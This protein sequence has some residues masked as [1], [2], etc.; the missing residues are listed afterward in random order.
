MRSAHAL[1]RVRDAQ[2]DDAPALQAIV[3]GGGSTPGE[4]HGSAGHLADHFV[5]PGEPARAQLRGLRGNR[6]AVRVVNGCRVT[7]ESRF[8]SHGNGPWL[9]GWEGGRAERHADTD[10]RP[11]AEAGRLSD[12]RGLGRRVARG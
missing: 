5:P 6:M 3:Q 4:A 2:P 7:S 11:I 12:R 1:A 10:D 8:R 9:F